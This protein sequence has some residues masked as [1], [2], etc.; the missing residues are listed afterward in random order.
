MLVR[1]H[2]IASVLSNSFSLK[3]KEFNN[4]YRDLLVRTAN[5]IRTKLEKI[6]AEDLKPNNT[7][8]SD[9]TEP[10]KDILISFDTLYKQAENTDVNID[11]YKTLEKL[12][13][14]EKSRLGIAIRTGKNQEAGRIKKRI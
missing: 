1:N 6:E 5:S 8:P 11:G 3:D 13:L 12:I 14:A 2:I 7:N 10:K 9:F 4:K